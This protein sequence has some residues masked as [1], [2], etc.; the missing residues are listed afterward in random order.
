MRD[1]IYSRDTKGTKYMSTKVHKKTLKDNK[2]SSILFD[3]LL[4]FSPFSGIEY[5]LVDISHLLLNIA[6]G[7]HLI[8]YSSF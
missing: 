8:L 6:S 7:N 2:Q 4:V 5:L 1:K 3:T